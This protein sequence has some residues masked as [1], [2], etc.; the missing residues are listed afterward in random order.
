MAAMDLKRDNTERFIAGALVALVVAIAVAMF[1]S[2]NTQPDLLWRG[3]YHDRNGHYAFG[4]DLALAVRTADPVWFFAELLKAQVWPPVHGLLLAA[5]LLTGGIDHR[6]GIVPSLIGWMLTVVFVA[7]IARRMFQDRDLGIAAAVVAAALAVAS[8][9]FRLLACDVMLE[10][11]GAALSAAALW[12]YGRAVTA[13]DNAPPGDN[14]APG[15]EAAR[16]RSRWRLL[17]IILTALFF[18]KGNYWGLVVMAIGVTHLSVRNASDRRRWIDAVRTVPAA[19][20]SVL[21]DPLII[22]AALVFGVVL[23][24]YHRGPTSVVLFQHA[25]SL[26]PPENLVTVTYALLLARFGLWWRE[27]RLARG[28]A[29]GPAGRAL[30]YWHLMPI[31]ISFLLP[32]RLSAFVWFVGPANATTGFDPLDG[33]VLYWHAFSDGFSATPWAAILTLVL[34]AIGLSQFGRYSPGGRAAF[35]LALVGFAGVVIHPQ[36]Q[37]RFLAS[38]LFAVWIGAGGGTAILLERLIGR[39]AR[40]PVAGGAAVVLALTLWR[41][42]PPA[43]YATAIYPID[44]PSDLDLVRPV[45]PDLD[46]LRSIAYAT[47]FG[48]STLLSWVVREHCRCKFT[49]ESPWIGGVS[50]ADARALMAARIASS[51]APAFVIIDAPAGPYALPELGWTYDRLAGIPDAMAAQDRYVRVAAHAVPQFGAE[52]SLWRLPPGREK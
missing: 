15:E 49:V 42:A 48:E 11:L 1:V 24:L 29:L 18:E 10:C 12:A 50:R 19:A 46:G 40:L 34:F 5:V 2:A 14:A 22:A 38:W 45:L 26:Y 13:G 30:L 17:A 52:V 25:V 27:R 43:A 32:R 33:V 21:F 35:A 28:T 51:Q 39:R 4:Q 41:N 23:Y 31:A 6:L 36:H 7:L 16:A 20:R 9:A 37:G 47:T 8:P 3:Y 44:G